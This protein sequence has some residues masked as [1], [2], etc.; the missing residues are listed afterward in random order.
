MENFSADTVEMMRLMVNEDWQAQRTLD[1]CN[2]KIA[3]CQVPRPEPFPS[4]PAMRGCVIHLSFEGLPPR[5][6]DELLSYPT[7]FSL[8]AEQV[9]RL[10]DAGA[11]LLA[12]S[13]D[14]QRL[15]RTLQREPALGSGVAGDAPDRCS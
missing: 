5:E 1:D 3:Q 6:R 13:A 15:V 4:T 11:A 8:T 7:S 14:F 2:A 12:R 10:I 9:Q